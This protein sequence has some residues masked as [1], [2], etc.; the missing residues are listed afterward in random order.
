MF[1]S[2]PDPLFDA[3]LSLQIGADMRVCVCVLVWVWG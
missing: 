1:A 3:K 2:F